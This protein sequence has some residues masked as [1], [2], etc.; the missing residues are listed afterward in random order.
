MQSKIKQR[1]D[2]LH[3][4]FNPDPAYILVTMEDGTEKEVTVNEYVRDGFDARFSMHFVKMLRGGTVEDA[5]RVL[6]VIDLWLIA[7]NGHP[8]ALCSDRVKK[9]WDDKTDKQKKHWLNMAANSEKTAS[10]LSA[11]SQKTDG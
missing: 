4:Q 10:S 11:N 7:E 3:A 9:W 6:D 8:S 1:I 2:E 5:F